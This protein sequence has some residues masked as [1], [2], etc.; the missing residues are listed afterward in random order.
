[1]R[2]EQG[3]YWEMSD[4]LYGVYAD[5]DMDA[6]HQDA[7][8]GEKNDGPEQI[9]KMFSEDVILAYAEDLGLDMAQFESCMEEGRTEDEIKADFD[10]AKRMG[11]WSII[12]VCGEWLL[13]GGVSRLCGLGAD[14]GA[15]F[16]RSKLYGELGK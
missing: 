16:G 14:F 4:L 5:F 12:G 13:C 15:S 8:S 10:A 2:R 9:K 1:M 7:P 11:I 6:I 3:A